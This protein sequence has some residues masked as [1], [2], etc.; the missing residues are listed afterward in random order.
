[1]TSNRPQSS[2]LDEPHIITHIQRFSIWHTFKRHI[3]H[4]LL[5]ILVDI[6]LPII[7]YVVLHKHTK[8]VNTL[9]IAGIPPLIMVIFKAI[10]SRTFDA[11]GFIAFLGFIISGVVAII[12]KNATI[13]LLE[14][15]LVS[16]IFSLIF[17]ITL[18]PFHCCHYQC[19]LRPLAY[20]FY[21]DLVP[22]NL[23]QIGLPENLFFFQYESNYEQYS[24][25][26]V[27]ISKLS[28][29]EEIAKVYEWIYTNCSSFRLSCYMITSFWSI[30]LL[31]EFLA[32]LTLILIHLSVNTIVIY[33]NVVLSSVAI[34]CI[35]MTII[36]ITRERKQTMILIEEWKRKHLNVQ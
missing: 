21:Q 20:Y 9:L 22:T 30:G 18:I 27:L 28:E 34:I 23:E 10:L 11:L 12:T 26:Q 8:P 1:M 16:G 24:E 17:G 36:C 35:L 32:R 14:K 6:I 31:F 19:R 4:F 5:T 13:L 29:R 2:S 25:H 3:P 33:G 15:S 7:I